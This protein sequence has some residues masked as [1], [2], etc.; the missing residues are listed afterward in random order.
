MKRLW[1]LVLLCSSLSASA[2]SWLS[3]AVPGTGWLLQQPGSPAVTYQVRA[4]DW[5]A[6]WS[7][8]IV[9]VTPVRL[10]GEAELIGAATTAYLYAQGNVAWLIFEDGTEQVRVWSAAD[11]VA[12][13][14][15]STGE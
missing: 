14:G 8:L 13:G 6:D 12:S 11:P 9:R 7:R 15:L 1:C 4:T 2:Q 3:T 5:T 10:T